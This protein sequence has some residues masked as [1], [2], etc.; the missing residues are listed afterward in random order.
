MLLKFIKK[1]QILFFVIFLLM[2]VAIMILTKKFDRPS[3][4]KTEVKKE[5]KILESNPKK[6]P[7]I[8]TIVARRGV[9]FNSKAILHIQSRNNLF[10]VP[11]STV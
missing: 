9:F 4:I 1:N 2:S 11:F 6:M 10:V 5:N 3:I 8:V 7:K